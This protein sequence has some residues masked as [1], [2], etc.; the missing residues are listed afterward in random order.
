MTTSIEDHIADTNNPHQVTKAQIGL[1]R[2][3]NYP[4]ASDAEIKA[5]T[6][7]DRYIRQADAATIKVAFNE[8]LYSIGLTDQQGWLKVAP[9]DGS[10]SAV[11]IIDPDNQSVTVRGAHPDAYS[12]D[13]FIH[14][15][16]DPYDPVHSKLDIVLVNGLWVANTAGLSLDPYQ[17]WILTVVHRTDNE[18]FMSKLKVTNQSEY[19]T[20]L[21]IDA[22]TGIS[23]LFGYAAGAGY[24]KLEVFEGAVKKYTKTDIPVDDNNGYFW[25]HKMVNFTLDPSKTYRVRTTLLRADKSEITHFDTVSSNV[26]VARAIQF[27][28]DP[29]DVGWLGGYLFGA[30]RIHAVVTRNGTVILEN[31]NV[32][33]NPENGI[34]SV[35]V[36]ALNLTTSDTFEAWVRG[37]DFRGN[38]LY[39]ETEPLRRVPWGEWDQPNWRD[40]VGIGEDDDDNGQGDDDDDNDNDNDNDDDNDD[41][42]DDHPW[43]NPDDDGWLDL[44][45]L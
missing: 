21:L 6:R 28:L 31:P 9:I 13:I 44:G 43:N 27:L 17:S 2:V 23:H 10:G 36:T 4:P 14:P 8:Y 37:Y 11:F 1:G 25:K 7:N 26:R 24:I 3:F 15:A 42:G 41:D 20:Y 16:D 39:D 18:E 22:L 29:F 33:V 12:V 35:D 40:W 32:I 38:E 30:V 34:W 19:V 45:E 5:L